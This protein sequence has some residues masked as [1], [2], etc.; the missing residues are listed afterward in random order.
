MI[1][2]HRSRRATIVSPFARSAD[3]YGVYGISDQPSFRPSRAPPLYQQVLDPNAH[4]FIGVG[5][6]AF[7]FFFSASWAAGAWVLCAELFP[8]QYRA[9]GVTLT[10]LANWACN[11][12]I[13]QITFKV[14]NDALLKPGVLFFFF[15][16]VCVVSFFYVLIF[17]P[18]TAGVKAEEI[19]NVVSRFGGE[20]AARFGEVSRSIS[21]GWSP[22]RERGRASEGSARGDIR[23]DVAGFAASGVH[24]GGG[25]GYGAVAAPRDGGIADVIAAT[26]AQAG[27]RAG[28]G[29]G[30]SALSSSVLS[31]SALSAS[32]LSASALSGGS[33]GASAATAAL[34]AP[35]AAS[36][37]FCQRTSLVLIAGDLWT[38]VLLLYGVAVVAIQPSA[39]GA[40]GANVD[41]YDGLAVM[42]ALMLCLNVILLFMFFQRDWAL[43]LFLWKIFLAL[44]S[45]ATLFISVTNVATGQ[46]GVESYTVPAVLLVYLC[47]S[48]AI[49]A[50]LSTYQRCWRQWIQ[51]RP[52][53][54]LDA[55][56]MSRRY[57][58]DGYVERDEFRFEQVR[59][60]LQCH[61]L[62]V[63]F[64]VFLLLTQI[65]YFICFV[66]SSRAI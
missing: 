6:I 1:S 3:V 8:T 52:T 41:L 45:V 4:G 50:V 62:C 66:A 5:L 46:S 42:W 28:S 25:T 43:I 44:S 63:L 56:V 58:D 55:F 36:M 14:T 30:E 27:E 10:T 16:G 34:R 60:S 2:T 61:I 53:Q 31:A 38:T 9:R 7:I 40:G 37:T 51:H 35:K 54:R 12:A 65:V 33:E 26:E 22:R 21:R 18:E 32:A 39:S 59:C 49:V 11:M 23:A 13:A 48:L 15:M 47:Y 57:H 29:G 64:L 19:V 17:V 24:G 20:S